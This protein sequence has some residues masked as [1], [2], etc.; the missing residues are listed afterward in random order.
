MALVPAASSMQPGAR[1]GPTASVLINEVAGQMRQFK[2]DLLRR[3]SEQEAKLNKIFEM[4]LER[5]NG[6]GRLDP[7]NEEAW[8]AFRPSPVDA[9]AEVLRDAVGLEHIG[10]ELARL[11]QQINLEL[12]LL[13]R[14][15]IRERAARAG[16]TVGTSP[17]ALPPRPA[18]ISDAR[19]RPQVATSVATPQLE[20]SPVYTVTSAA[21][22][23]PSVIPVQS[24]EVAPQEVKLASWQKGLTAREKACMTP[25]EHL[26]ATL[27]CC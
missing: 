21:N 1:P 16:E 15:V 4:M 18:A 24:Q 5:S 12:A 10:Q 14:E 8:S 22:E 20:D 9:P 19:P 25:Q 3:H 13:S 7:Q 11:Q 17:F 26:R 23:V 2:N 27:G 6:G